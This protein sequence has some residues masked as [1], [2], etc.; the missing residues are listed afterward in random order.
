[1]RLILK[2][3]QLFFALMLLS[4]ALFA[5]NANIR[6]FVYEKA[7]GEP[8][9]FTSVILA[10]TKYGVQTDVN[11]Y[12][13]IT[14]LP[15]GTYNLKVVALGFDTISQSV[16][17]KD[18]EIKSLKLFAEKGSVKLKEVSISADRQE[19]TTEVR[20]S[21]NKITPKEI[22]QIPTVGGEPDLA[23]YLQ[24]LPGVVFTGDQGGQLYIRGGSP[25]QNK[26]LMDG[27]IIYNPF[28]SI[29]LFSVFD[30][31]VIRNADVYT[32]G[33]NAEYGGRIS[34]IMDITTRDGNK[35]RLSGK[36]AISP[37]GAKT[38]LE[39]PLSKAK[40][41]GG[42]STS[43]LLS[44]KNSYL[45]QSSKAL[46]GYI[47]P[48]GLPFDFLDLYGKVSFNGNNGSKLNVFGFNFMDSVKYQAISNLKW[49]SGGGGANFVVIPSSSQ[50]LIRGNFAYSK[51]GISLSESE[52]QPRSSTIDGFNLGLN[53]TYF[54]GKNE[55]VYGV[56]LLGSQTT[57][58]FYNAYNRK[59]SQAD[60]NTEFAGFMRY[61]ANI[62]DKLILDP[63]FRLHYYASLNE[64]SPEP[65]IGFKYNVVKNFRLKGAAG[66]YSQ[67]LISANSDRD[68]VNLFYGFISG[69]E[70]VQTQFTEQDGVT[71]PV[72]SRLQKSS[73]LI[74]GFELDLTRDLTLNVE[75][76]NKKFGQLT[77]INRNK[78]FDDNSLNSDRPETERKDFIIESG[79]ARGL[80]FSL[81]YDY[82]RLY[83]W[84]VY[85]LSY[86]K[87]WDGVQEYFPL[88]D[89]RHN[90]N[91]TGSYTFGKALDWEFNARWNMGSGFAFTQ[92]QGFYQNM[93]FA[94]GINTDIT[95]SNG[96]LGII[97]GDLNTGRL[98]YYHRL[99]LTVKKKFELTENS[100]L[101]LNAGATNAYNR[102][103]VFY[104]DRVKGETVYQLPLMP[105][106]GASLNF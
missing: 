90:V 74:G 91:L 86:V 2:K 19:A 7:T 1:M 3:T 78:K 66:L 47:N 36:V 28:H 69:P 61:K 22:K 72:T 25:V 57:F 64:V 10:G 48:D 31:D 15:A 5:Q 70:N 13:S 30:A 33:F 46:Y 38:L 62:G 67:N 20:T 92:N 95:T 89:R 17:V 79:Y 52:S 27:M 99:D 87:R 24:V 85:S 26:V 88:F 77:N 45:S 6:G 103:N 4:T 40:E 32:G 11:G 68:V 84:A 35:K 12:F 51:Y 97:Y 43:F 8:S 55:L 106:I 18:G 75:A 102:K 37:F 80:D 105:T 94:S 50:I 9:I 63:S 65:R 98:P 93:D 71:N 56:E 54:T 42:S 44:A 21:V 60:N 53:F 58:D 104:V 14:K 73:H 101:E 23:Q 39:G 82:K 59:I 100:T 96:Q 29:G 34:S 49:T 83:L 41:E 81:K 16:S 76:Y